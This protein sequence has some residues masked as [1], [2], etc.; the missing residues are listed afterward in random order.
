MTKIMV[1]DDEKD[2]LYLVKIMLK[3]DE[4]ELILCSGGNIALEKLREEKP[5]LIFLDIMMPDMTGM[6]VCRKI[7]ENPELK[8][9][10]VIM[11]T[12]LDKKEKKIEAFYEYGC[13]GYITKPFSKEDLISVIKWML[14]K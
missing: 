10:P 2:I 3:E 5:D 13:D 7:K 4:Y 11:L 12:V 14:K 6:E 1:V 9:I 8:E